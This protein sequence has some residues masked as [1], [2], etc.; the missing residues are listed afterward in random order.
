[1]E[2]LEKILNKYWVFLILVFSIPAVWALFVPGFYGASDEVHIAWLNQMDK[3]LKLGQIPARFVPDLSFGFG[4]PLFNFVFPLP[5]YIAEIFHLFFGFSF[6]DSIKALFFITIPLSG[7]FMYLLLREFVKANLSFLGALLYIYT[8]Y[9]A[10]DL[11]VRG[12]IGEVLSFIF[13]PLV[14]LS[15]TKLNQQRNFK[16]VGI[17]ALALASLVLSH[18]ITAYMFIPFV[19][20]YL[21]LQ[22]LKESYKGVFFRKSVLMI[23]LSLLM[24]AF[25]WL[26]AITESNLVKYDTIFKFYDHFPAIRQLLTPYWGYGAS[27]PGEGDGMSFFLGYSSLLVLIFA[28]GLLFLKWK[29]ISKDKKVLF[30]WVCSGI[31][32]AIFFTNHRST[33]VWNS[34]PLMPYFQFPWRFLILTTFFIPLLVIIFDKSKFEKIILIILLAFVVYPTM[35]YFKPEHFLGRLDDYYL[36]KYIPYPKVSMEYLQH[37]EEYLRLPKTSKQ[38]PDM[39]YPIIFS[40]RNPIAP[41]IK[42]NDLHFIVSVYVNEETLINFNKYYFPGWLAKLDGKNINI[43]AGSPF[44]QISVLVPKGVHKLEVFFAETPYK[45]ALDFASLLGFL[46]S[47]CLSLKY[48][49]KI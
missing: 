38:R 1:M 16:W 44:G 36:N 10:V 5:F 33:F 37:Q 43:L 14:I 39:I 22:F 25:F 9:R 46:V 30:I 27:V 21:L 24:S 19:L 3:V 41:V 2:K 15:I 12:A 45:L 17:G 20:L 42:I 28:S 13:L 26:P 4:Y 7:I 49:R 23:F 11:Y 8:P 34:L 48:F 29:G 18:N 40:L 47:L 35:S 32:L 6:V 31:F